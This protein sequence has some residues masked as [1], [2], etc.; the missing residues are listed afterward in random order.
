M[1]GALGY[2][3][4]W[5]DVGAVTV[6]ENRWIAML[7]ANITPAGR[8][9]VAARLRFDGKYFDHADVQD[10]IWYRFRLNPSYKTHLGQLQLAPYVAVEL[11]GDTKPQSKI[12]FNRNRLYVGIFVTLG[13]YLRPRIEYM[14][15]QIH[16]GSMDHA[17]RMHLI[18][19]I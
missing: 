10:Y 7:G 13:Q 14:R 1:Y 9:A 2:R 4:Q 8:F 3:R 12:F 15:Q 5:N 18:W 6:N 16:D 19:T 17:I 11:F